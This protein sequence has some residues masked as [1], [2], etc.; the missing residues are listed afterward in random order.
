MD[1]SDAYVV[2]IMLVAT[3]S[4]GGANGERADGNQ[5]SLPSQDGGNDPANPHADLDDDG[6]LEIDATVDDVGD[7]ASMHGDSGKQEPH[8]PEA[9]VDASAGDSGH[10]F[11][12]E[13]EPRM[14]TVGDEIV[15]RGRFAG[16]Q[17]L[18]LYDAEPIDYVVLNEDALQVVA[19]P[20]RERVGCA[21]DVDIVVQ[22]E[23]G[24]SLPATV[25]VR[26]PPPR[27]V[28]H[29]ERARAGGI[30]VI[31]GANLLDTQLVLG[32]VVVLDAAIEAN[33]IE[34]ALP[35]NMPSGTV[36]LSIT[37]EC[38]NAV[39]SVEVLPPLPRVIAMDPA[40]QVSAEGLL[41]LTIDLGG[42]T[43]IGAVRFNSHM[44]ASDDASN[45]ARYPNASSDLYQ[46]AVRVPSDVGTG[47]LDLALVGD[48]GESDPIALNVI[49]LSPYEPPSPHDITFAT[50]EVNSETYPLGTESAYVLADNA[51]LPINS[52][53]TAWTYD[54]WFPEMRICDDWGEVGGLEKHCNDANGCGLGNGCWPENPPTACHTIT[55]RFRR[56]VSGNQLFLTID[57]T[58]SG[59]RLENYSGGWIE[60]EPLYGLIWTT[61]VLRS[62]LSGRQITI[63]ARLKFGQACPTPSP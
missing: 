39:V 59:G 20:P 58:S 47:P 17:R 16:S 11:V 46:L 40:D 2:A 42:A 7:D 5:R 54:M 19:R 52:P 4:C 25:E 45:F 36:D 12:I 62:D 48:S 15:V 51:G 55:G 61:M 14:V 35:A 50:P 60:A 26:L 34:I 53:G 22:T 9:S 31:E 13:V 28:E 30:V 24:A 6:R 44:V 32:G 56:D 63:R 10:G 43:T 33:R 37:G 8:K 57:R 18:V 21:K 38:G 3:C 23:A 41:F 49:G 1:R 27:V 29:T